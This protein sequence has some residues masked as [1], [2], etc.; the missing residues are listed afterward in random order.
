MKFFHQSKRY[1]HKNQRYSEKYLFHIL[2]PVQ[3]QVRL[4]AQL[5]HIIFPNAIVWDNRKD[6]GIISKSQTHLSHSVRVANMKK[7]R[8]ADSGSPCELYGSSFTED[9]PGFR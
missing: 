3:I 9:L 7:A 1:A 6:F 8:T 4:S 5:Y 2:S